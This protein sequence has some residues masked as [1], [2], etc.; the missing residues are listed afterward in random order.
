MSRHLYLVAYDVRDPRRL[1]RARKI[2]RAW[3]DRGQKSVFECSLTPGERAQVL[4]DLRRAIDPEADR[5]FVLRLRQNATLWCL[6]RARPPAQAR[7]HVIG[8]DDDA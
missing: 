8:G 1:A 4:H 6:G 7:F 5:A 3:S 2:L